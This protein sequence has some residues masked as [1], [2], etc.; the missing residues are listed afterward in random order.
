LNGGS[1]G[2]PALSINGY[3]VASGT[4]SCVV[5][6]SQGSELLFCTEAPDVEFYTN[7]TSQLVNGTATVEF[8]R[9]YKEAISTERPVRVVVVPA[10]SWSAI[11]VVSQ[12]P[13]GFMV[14]SE[15]GDLNAKFN[16]IAIGIRK[17]YESRPVLPKH[18]QPSDEPAPTPAAGSNEGGGK[19]RS[20]LDD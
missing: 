15:S 12:T 17:G 5:K 1:S 13:T 11:Y 4:K 9:L 8:E 6:T 19:F 3:M 16:W 14:K 10:G 18:L 20:V 2:A 7:G